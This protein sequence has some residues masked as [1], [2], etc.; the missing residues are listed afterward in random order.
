MGPGPWF[1][2]HVHLGGPDFDA[3]RE[4]VLARAAA[5]GVGRLVEIGD[6]P[7]DWPRVLALARAWPGVLRCALGL[8]PYYAER[9]T[10]A[11]L[12]DLERQ[13]RLPEV[14]AVGE[15]GLDYARGPVAPE[16]QK[17]ALRRLLAA[18]RDW[19][20]PAVIHCR[21]AYEDLRL[22]VKEVFPSPPQGRRFWGVVHCF[23]G[24]PEDAESLAAGGW[25]L[26]ADGPATYPKNAAL[27]EA[28]RRAG[29]EVTVLETDS[30]YLPPQSR[31]GKRNEPDAVPEIA[32]ALAQVWALPAADVARATTAN[33]EEL[34]RDR[35][36]NT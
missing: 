20:K 1:D 8:H 35:G 13:A 2:T 11:F 32:A 19:G 33:A 12:A 22:I 3:D 7:E 14:V 36:H 21:G 16:I 26:G 23:S 4:A 15:I 10:D 29:P 25:A 9:C 34:F 6:A 31:R 24:T 5:A 30:P 28:F 18:C 27:R 17:A